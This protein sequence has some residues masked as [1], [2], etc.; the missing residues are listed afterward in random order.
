MYLARFSYDI[1]PVDRR[2]AI[3]FIQQEVKAARDRGLHARLLVPLTRE[4]GGPA[5]QF[6]IQ[7][8][9]LEQLEDF[10]HRGVG[11]DKQTGD[12]MQEFSKLLLS[13]PAVE[14][15]RVDEAGS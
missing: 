11:S 9:N 15:L 5:L 2:Q 8:S 4:H 6:E 12:W 10:R 7:L 1:S 14:I 3:D 13:P